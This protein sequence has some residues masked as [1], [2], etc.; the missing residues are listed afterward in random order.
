VD[1][2]HGIKMSPAAILASDA[3]MLTHS[4]A[5]EYS[6]IRRMIRD[7]TEMIFLDT[8]SILSRIL[9][10]SQWRDKTIDIILLRIKGSKRS[11][12]RI[13][14]RNPRGVLIPSEEIENL[15]GE[16]GQTAIETD[17]SMF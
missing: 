11:R 5:L 15:V 2:G 3:N 1:C 13:D 4:S 9:A 8:R 17:S 10:K 12:Q 7:N 16:T 6:G 14:G